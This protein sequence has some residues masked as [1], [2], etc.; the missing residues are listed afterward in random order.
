[1]D[2]GLTDK[3]ALVIGATAGLGLATAQVLV[4]EGARVV[5]CGRQEA[6]LL[7]ALATLPGARGLCADV[8]VAADT[9][10]LLEFTLQTLA[11]L[12]ILIVNAGGPPAGNFDSLDQ[13]TWEQAVQL[14]LLSAVALIRAALPALRRSSAPSILTITSVSV[15]QPIEGLLLSNAIRPA[16]AGLTK[17]LALELGAEGIRVNSIL[18]GWTRTERVDYLLQQRAQANN[19]DYETELG[20]ITAAIPLRRMAEP[21]EFGRIAAFLSSPAA[22]YLTGVMLQVDGGAYRGTF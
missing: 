20:R 7:A 12:D 16:V 13:S 14:T 1:M 17:S 5:I 3:K 4:A 9:D 22:S 11:G 10:R 8:T 18:P 19:S 21:A 15:K 6:R 2:L